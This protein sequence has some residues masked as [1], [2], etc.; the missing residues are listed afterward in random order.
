MT[1]LQQRLLEISDEKYAIF[2]AKL[3]PTVS[4]ERFIGVRVPV[5]RKFAKG[6]CKEAECKTFMHTLP[7]QYYDEDMLHSLLISQTKDY[8]TC[9]SQLELFLPYI[10]NWAVCDILSPKIF[11]KY[12]SMLLPKICKWSSSNHTYTCRFGIEMLMTFYLDKDF[13]PEYHKIPIAVRSDDYY[14]K[15]MVAWYFATALAKQWNDTISI[16]EQQRL[17]TWTHNKTIQK[18]IESYRITPSQKEYL[19]SLKI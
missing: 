13:L 19:R 18:A 5:L 14:I 15:M 12:K 11:A 4:Q 3:T 17:A 9:I 10:D 16:I 6:Y 7:H 1:D 8:D 2:Q